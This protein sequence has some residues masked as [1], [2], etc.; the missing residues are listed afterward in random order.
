VPLVVDHQ[1]APGETSVHVG[2]GFVWDVAHSPPVLSAPLRERDS[3]PPAHRCP[4]PNERRASTSSRSTV[5]PARDVVDVDGGDAGGGRRG[6][7]GRRPSTASTTC[8]ARR[9]DVARARPRAPTTWS[10]SRG[11]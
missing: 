6:W 8:V 9:G 5:L 3:A 2:H 1:D 11:P 7:R 4:T 10:A